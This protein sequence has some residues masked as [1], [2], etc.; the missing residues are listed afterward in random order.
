LTRED[1]MRHGSAFIALD[2][3]TQTLEDEGSADFALVFCALA[4]RQ[5]RHMSTVFVASFEGARSL[6]GLPW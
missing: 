1:K 3:A 4:S 5:S 2:A 6:C